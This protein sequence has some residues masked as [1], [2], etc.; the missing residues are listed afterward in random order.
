MRAN[1]SRLASERLL[2]KRQLTVDSLQQER[3]ELTRDKADL[4]GE[5]QALKHSMTWV[6]KEET[7]REVV[8]LP[9]A[10][11]SESVNAKDISETKAPLRKV[12]VEEVTLGS[13][14]TEPDASSKVGHPH[15]PVF[16]ELRERVGKFSRK[17]GDNDFC[18]WLADFEEVSEDC[19]W[20]NDLRAKW[21]SRF[22]DGPAKATWLQTL[23]A[24][25]K[26]SWSSI[27]TIYQAQFGVHMDPQTAYRRCHELQYSDIGSVQGLLEVMREYQ[28]MALSKLSDWNQSYGIRCHMPCSEKWE[29]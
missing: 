3:D 7:T 20:T 12:T 10:I 25:E 15:P 26:T 16:K 1:D 29:K 6:G 21:F 14:E 8:T 18:I 2:A 11:S 27:E 5:L 24:E 13:E 19:K 4:V 17:R 22:V 28:R 23:T 9:P